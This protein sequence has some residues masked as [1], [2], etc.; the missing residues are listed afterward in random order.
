MIAHGDSPD[1]PAW[2]PWAKMVFELARAAR[3]GNP[4]IGAA[5]ALRMVVE[6]R[7]RRASTDVISRFRDKLTLGTT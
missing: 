5:Q 7:G 1:A 4:L 2:T 3:R 6:T